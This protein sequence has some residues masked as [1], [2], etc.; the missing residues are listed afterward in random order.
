MKKNSKVGF[1]DMNSRCNMVRSG[2]LLV[3]PS[4]MLKLYQ[5]SVSSLALV[6][7]ASRLAGI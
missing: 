5:I 4:A 7:A 3:Q 1:A 6:M 2:G